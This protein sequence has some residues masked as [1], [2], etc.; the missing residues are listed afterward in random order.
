MGAFYS[1]PNEIFKHAWRPLT[2]ILNPG[3]R[4]TDFFTSVCSFVQLY[5][6]GKI[7]PSKS[8]EL[9]CHPGHELEEYRIDSDR[10]TEEPMA[11][12]MANSEMINYDAL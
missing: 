3:C 9:M 8:Y 12:I 2:F 10:L 6:A 4:T 7:N 5:N 11:T 1:I